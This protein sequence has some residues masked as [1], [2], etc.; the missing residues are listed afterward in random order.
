MGPSIHSQISC[1]L[2][3]PKIASIFLIFPW[4]Y[5]CCEDSAGMSYRCTSE[6]PQYMFSWRKKE[7][8]IYN[9]YYLELWTIFYKE[10]NHLKFSLG[11]WNCQLICQYMHD[12]PS[13][14]KAW[15]SFQFESEICYKFTQETY[16]FQSKLA[17]LKHGFT[18]LQIRGHFEDK[19]LLFLPKKISCRWLTGIALPRQIIPLH[20]QDIFDE[21]ITKILL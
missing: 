18:L 1:S 3:Q 7:K 4:K 5:I 8:Y 14:V 2:I 12:K 17:L 19:F 10:K 13:S 16:K 15:K 20:S 11:P 6:Y 21:K 9:S